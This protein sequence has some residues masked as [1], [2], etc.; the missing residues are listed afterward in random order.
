M[1]GTCISILLLAQAP[2]STYDRYALRLVYG[3]GSTGVVRGIQAEAVGGGTFVPGV[4]LL[5]TADDSVRLQYRAS[6]ASFKRYALLGGISIAGALATMNYYGDHLHRDWNTPIGI[7]LPLTTLVVGWAGSANAAGGE[8]HLRRAIWLY[9]R[10][11]QRAPDSASSDCAY[12]RCA[13]RVQRRLLSTQ[14][15]RGIDGAP[16]GEVGSRADLFAA[17]NDSSRR[18]YE[19]FRTAYHTARTARHVGLVAYL[20]AGTLFAVGQSKLA[21]GFG[22]GFLVVGYAAAHGSVYATAQA[23]SELDQAIW[24]YN[25]TLPD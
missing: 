25:G 7:G 3:P 23:A 18:H 21:R 1:L 5:A 24:F 17:A 9:N 11:F 15:V 8:D 4:E 14:I 10:R 16:L 6:R 22:V 13:L 19:A 2:E 12:D 20:S